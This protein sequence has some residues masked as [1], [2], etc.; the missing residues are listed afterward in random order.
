[1]HQRRKKTVFFLISILR[2]YLFALAE[3]GLGWVDNH[4]TWY[5]NTLL[6]TGRKAPISAYDI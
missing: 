2:L 5:V 3:R 4:Y 6:S 1:M